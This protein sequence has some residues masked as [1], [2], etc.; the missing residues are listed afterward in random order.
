MQLVASKISVYFLD[1]IGMTVARTG[2]I[3]NLP[4]QNLEVADA[5]S[6]LR[7]LISLLALGALYAYM[8]QKKF[9]AQLILFLSTIPM[10]VIGNIFRVFVTSILVYTIPNIQVTEEPLHSLLGASVFVIVFILLFAFSAILR[11]I[12]R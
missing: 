5:C 6:G 11:K 2:N 12:F 8:F 1:L 3:I 4:G 9:T 10:A 7:S